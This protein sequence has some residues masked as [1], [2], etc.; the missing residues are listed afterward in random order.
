MFGLETVLSQ[1][2]SQP[3]FSQIHQAT[4]RSRH[5]VIFVL[6]YLVIYDRRCFL[7]RPR[8]PS[9]RRFI[10]RSPPPVFDHIPQYTPAVCAGRQPLSSPTGLVRVERTGLVTACLSLS[11]SPLSLPAGDGAF[12]VGFAALLLADSSGNHPIPPFFYLLILLYLVM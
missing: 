6:L 4:I 3:F 1:S 7:S 5:L 11:L 2:A 9:S 8:S 10:R 12:S